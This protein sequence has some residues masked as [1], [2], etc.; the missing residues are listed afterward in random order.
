[1][2]AFIAFSTNTEVRA[3]LICCSELSMHGHVL[4]LVE[5]V[6]I[7]NKQAKVSVMSSYN[8]GYVA[9]LV[10]YVVLSDMV[11]GISKRR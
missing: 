5:L 2:T 11:A 8:S 10:L 4:M 6:L 1:M 3:R 7:K 9:I